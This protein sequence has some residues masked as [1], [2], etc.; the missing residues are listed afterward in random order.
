MKLS[1]ASIVSY[2]PDNSRSWVLRVLYG[3]T[4]TDL[5]VIGWAVVVNVTDEDGTENLI[6]PVV[7]GHE[8]MPETDIEFERY[9]GKGNAVPCGLFPVTPEEWLEA[10]HWGTPI[11]QP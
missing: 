8:A 9:A 5:P 4:L 3:K 7:Y 1:D 2:E 10:T 11:T 6:H